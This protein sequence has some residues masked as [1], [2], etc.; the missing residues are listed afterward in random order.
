MLLGLGV[1]LSGAVALLRW[2]SYAAPIE[3]AFYSA[4]VAM[5]VLFSF[6]PERKTPGFWKGIGCSAV[7]HCAVLS[8]IHRLFPFSTV[9]TV[10]PIAFVEF[11]LVA[12]VMIEF[13]GEE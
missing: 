3:M 4:L 1:G 8:V 6:W 12:I 2:P 5:A 13:V 11:V 10:L 7:L 9:L